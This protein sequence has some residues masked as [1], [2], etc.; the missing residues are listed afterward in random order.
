MK[1]QLG[2]QLEPAP[3][4]RRTSVLRSFHARAHVPVAEA[5]AGEANAQTQEDQVLAWMKAH[6]GRHTPPEVLAGLGTKAPLTSIRRCLS[7]LTAA[8]ELRHWPA[9]RRP[10]I[11]GAK[12]STWEAM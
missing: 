1:Q 6:P 2:L 5:L 4:A 10:G 7:D 8:F 12:N 11:Y 3:T 9:D